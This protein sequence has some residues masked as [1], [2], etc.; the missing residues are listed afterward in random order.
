VLSSTGSGTDWVSLSEISGVDGTGT[1][2]YVAKWSDADTIANSQIRDDGTT[3][4]IGQAP[5][6][7][8][9]SVAGNSID[10]GGKVT[11]KKVYG[12]GVDTTG[13]A[14]AGLPSSSNGNSTLLEFTCS[15]GA[16]HYQKIVYSC[17]NASAVWYTKKV[18]DE[19]TNAFDVEASA[20]AATITFTFKSRSGLQQYTPK[21]VVEAN[22]THDTSYL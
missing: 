13:V 2:N 14:V 9:L 16:G 8:K 7:A 4:G 21:I 22:G 1:A 15:G 12:S 19:G 11:Y 10:A 5:G 6:A 17:W 20:D 18:V 3:V